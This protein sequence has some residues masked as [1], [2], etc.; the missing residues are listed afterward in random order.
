MTKDDIRINLNLS[1]EEAT[2]IRL[3]LSRARQMA[4]EQLPG[5]T[6]HTD[7]WKQE[8]VINKYQSLAHKIA[9]E[10]NDQIHA[11]WNRRK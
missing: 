11:A 4:E 1:I 8:Q 5:I 2:W 7:R 9:Q 6:N 10:Q 3:A